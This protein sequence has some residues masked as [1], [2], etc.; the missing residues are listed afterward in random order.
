MPRRVA[1]RLYDRR[2]SADRVTARPGALEIGPDDFS[3]SGERL[4]EAIDLFAICD[5]PRA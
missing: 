1:Q 2:L 3:L 5:R 4:D